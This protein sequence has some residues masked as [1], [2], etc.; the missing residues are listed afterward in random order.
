MDS[1]RYKDWR[2]MSSCVDIRQLKYVCRL[3]Y[4]DSLPDQARQDGSVAVL[5]SNGQF[6]SHSAANTLSPVIVVGRKGSF[7]KLTWSNEPVFAIDTTYYID[8]STTNAD[9]RWLYYVLQTLHLDTASQDAAVPGLNREDAYTRKLTVPAI[10]DQR[11]IAAFLDRETAQ[12]DD[13]IAAK[14]RLLE[15]LVEK[16]YALITKAVTQ[17][18]DRSVLMKDSELPWLGPVPIHWEIRPLK[19]LA[20]L[21]TG[22]TLGKEYSRTQRMTTRPYLRVANVQDGEID[23]TDVSEI[24]VPV[25]E[26]VRYELRSGDVLLTEG[27]DLDKLGRG[28]VWQGQIPGCLHQ[29]HIFAV[30]P[31][32][33]LLL[34]EYLASLTTSAHGKNYFTSTGIRT[35]NLATTN[36]TKLMAFPVPAPP[37]ME[38][39]QIVRYVHELRHSLRELE[40][41]LARTIKTLHERRGSLIAAAVT[42]QIDLT[43]G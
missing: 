8:A 13:L 27:G 7:G 15:V 11:A 16:R 41:D 34:P 38:Q 4:G 29:N 25:D 33:N 2:Q 18:L 40:N 3:N 30:R 20:G 10:S 1:I 6:A 43:G 17:G 31:K 37:L 32:Q 19:F 42:G 9:M 24:T 39:E 35:T 28:Q 26:A 36:S 12:I 21:Q 23:T 5:G 14:Q 22:L